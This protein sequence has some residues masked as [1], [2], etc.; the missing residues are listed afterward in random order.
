M[1]DPAA[2]P[3]PVTEVRLVETH[4]SWVFLTGRI[5]YKVKK[6]CALGF[7]DFSTL[8]RR[9]R[10]CR[11]E[12]RLSGRFAPRL[13]LGVVPIT[14]RPER[15]LVEGPGTPLE[16]AVKLVQFDEADRLDARFDGGRLTAPD[17]ERLGAEIAA[18]Q[19]TLAV[20]GAHT[21]WGTVEAVLAAATLNL[22]Q[23]SGLRPDAA[24][25]VEAIGGWL[26]RRLEAL[27]PLLEARRA[28]GRVRECHGDLHLANIVLHDGHMTAFDAIEF[29]EPL[30]WIDT[31][32]DLAFLTMDLRSR[33]R[34]DLAAQALSG[35]IEA[36]DDHAAVALM[37]A[38]EVARAVVRATVAAIR[39]GQ[40]GLPPG[41]GG[42]GLPPGAGAQ[43]LPPDDPSRAETA[44]YLALAARISCP[45]RPALFA[46]SGV[47]G[48]GKTT[49]ASLL[50]GAAGAVRV[51][52][53][54]ERKRL[55]G[56]AAT[57]R[58]ADD[59]AA[60]ALYSPA[61]TRR[62]YERLAQLA[63]T[64]LGGGSSVVIDAACTLRWQRE[65]L[66]RAARAAGAP[67][68][69]LD[70]QVPAA[71]RVA[72]VAA[73]EAGGRDA[74]DASVAIVRDQLAAREP[75]TAA[76][77]EADGTTLVSVTPERLADPGFIP[78]V[79]RLPGV[80]G[81]VIRPA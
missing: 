57:E 28:A 6:P 77:A 35:W 75:L 18:V 25:Q 23:L 1:L 15:P 55:A 72:R 45:E 7:L 3:H 9:L 38:Y 22:G 51:R 52:S 40:Q 27:R 79:A 74:S 37:P 68:V 31:A 11:E 46:T 60:R 59:A 49:L 48:S 14:G 2:Y 71:E 67:L 53:D 5:V 29:S 36:A 73:R 8:D 50:V 80:A 21:A 30:R 4:I 42:R 16:W 33:G 61:M 81:G 24:P 20:A 13:Y 54:V 70:R 17:C 43:G 41:A 69:W 26:A 39:A 10:C 56:M 63:G 58:P 62:V 19:R 64:M 12:V 65:T 76:E 32:F 44:R 47:S 34:F 66:A 78:S